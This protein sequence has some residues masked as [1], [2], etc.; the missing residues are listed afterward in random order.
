MIGEYI[1]FF[2][3]YTYLLIFLFTL[4]NFKK[5]WIWDTLY[6]LGMMVG[7]VGTLITYKTEFLQ[8]YANITGIPVMDIRV[9]SIIS[10]LLIIGILF[11]YKPILYGK[12]SILFSSLLLLVIVGMYIFYFNPNDIYPYHSM[13]NIIPMCILFYI[14]IYILSYHSKKLI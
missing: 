7:L 4:F 9:F 1:K 10:H 13:E 11:I 6:S 3:L 8:Y 5:R 12:S 2:T 14:L